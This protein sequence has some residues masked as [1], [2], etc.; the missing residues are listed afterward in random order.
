LPEISD[1]RRATVEGGKRIERRFQKGKPREDGRA[2][3]AEFNEIPVVIQHIEGKEMKF[4]YVLALLEQNHRLS[5]WT[6]GYIVELALP[7]RTHCNCA[8]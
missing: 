5:A 2:V 3:D 8:R 6:P 1:Y 7:V 4:K